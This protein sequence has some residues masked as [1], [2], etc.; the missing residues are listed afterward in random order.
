M[1]NQNAKQPAPQELRYSGVLI[2][3]EFSNQRISTEE[4]LGYLI[5]FPQEILLDH[6]GFH[7]ER[8]LFSTSNENIM[9][10]K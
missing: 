5:T 4:S 3:A 7:Y 8:Y 9:F 1:G 6:L 2:K 10:T